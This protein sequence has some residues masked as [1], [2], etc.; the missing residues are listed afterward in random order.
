MKTS[1][2]LSPTVAIAGFV[3]AGLLAPAVRAQDRTTVVAEFS[4]ARKG[5]LTV[6][7][8]LRP[9]GGRAGAFRIASSGYYGSTMFL[10]EKEIAALRAAVLAAKPAEPGAAGKSNRIRIPDASGSLWVEAVYPNKEILMRWV[11]VES[12]GGSYP[13]IVFDLAAADFDELLKAI[14]EVAKQLDLATWKS[15]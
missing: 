8:E 15:K 1:R 13:P 10:H 9:G 11:K 4:D 3:I 14:D 6:A 7:W 2:F 12:D 5:H